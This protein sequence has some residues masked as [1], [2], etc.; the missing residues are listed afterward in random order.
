L[1]AWEEVRFPATERLAPLPGSTPLRVWARR[2]LVHGFEAGARSKGPAVGAFE[3]T[4]PGVR[5]ALL[6]VAAGG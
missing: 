5:C 4:E 1:T 3:R 2:L 6:V